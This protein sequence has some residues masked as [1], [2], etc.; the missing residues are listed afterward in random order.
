MSDVGNKGVSAPSEHGGRAYGRDVDSKEFWEQEASR[1][2]EHLGDSRQRYHRG[3]LDRARQMLAAS[4][5]PGDARLLDF[6]C[7]DG[8]LSLELARNGYRVLGLDIAESMI[9]LARAD[10]KDTDAVFE[11]GAAEQLASLEAASL[12]G[13]VSLNVLAYLTDGEMASFWQGCRHALRPG[14]MLLVSHSNELFDMFALNGGTAQFFQPNFTDGEPVDSLLAHPEHDHP[15]YNHRANPLSYPD[16][17]DRNGFRETDQ[18]FFNYHPLPP[19][20]LPEGDEGAITDPERID[21]IERWRQI[22]Q[23]STYFSLSELRAD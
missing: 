4:S 6:G 14:G 2:K 3:R 22:F 19:R 17:L 16:E 9:E 7:G 13:I 5:L 8:I 20:M 15:T 12:D 23:C 1:H 21:E 11:V 10:G 18:R